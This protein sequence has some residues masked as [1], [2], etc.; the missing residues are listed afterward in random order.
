MN[1]YKLYIHECPNTKKYIG[2]T[3]QDVKKRWNYGNG[4]KSCVLFYKAIKKYG[5]N[6]IKHEILYDDLTKDQAE[7]L[8]IELIAKYKTNQKE[9]GY[10]ICSGGNGTPNHIVS[11]KT[12]EKISIRT[13]EAMDNEK[14]K[15]KIRNCH[16]GKKLSEEHKEKIRLSSRKLQ[17]EEI[18]QKMRES[19]K[20][21]IKVRCIETGIVYDSIHNASRSTNISYQNI[22]KVCKGERKMAGGYKWKYEH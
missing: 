15:E 22:Y 11:D 13:K 17:T 7:Q 5:W 6:N 10:N 21:K 14:V 12:K 1:K 2:I 18:K 4:Y 8:E 19:N 20:N 16:L 9:F 3:Q